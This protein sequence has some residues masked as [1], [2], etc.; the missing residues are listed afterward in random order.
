M[1]SKRLQVE[2]SNG[3]RSVGFPFEW[4]WL[5]DVLGG[6]TAFVVFRGMHLGIGPAPR[7]KPG[8]KPGSKR[9]AK[10]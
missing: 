2:L 5:S 8:P 1:K 3:T 9:R 6:D 4:P 7:R 10:R